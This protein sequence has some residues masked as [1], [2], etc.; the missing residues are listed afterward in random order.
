MKLELNIIQNDIKIMEKE[1]KEKKKMEHNI[2]NDIDNI[3]LSEFDNTFKNCDL[4]NK[5]SRN[6]LGDHEE[7]PR[8]RRNS[9]S[10]EETDGGAENTKVATSNDSDNE[11][12]ISL[13]YLPNIPVATSNDLNT[14]PVA[15]SNDLNTIPVATSNDLNTIPVATSNDLNTIPVATSNDSDNESVISLSYLPNIPVATSNDSDNESVISLSYLPNIPVATSNDLNT[16]PVATSNDLNTIPVATSNDLNTIP[17]ATSN[18]SDNE[19]VISLGNLS[20]TTLD[21]FFNDIDNNTTVDNKSFV[22]FKITKTSITQLKLK[23]VLEIIK[24]LNKDNWDSYFK[25]SS[26]DSRRT[27]ESGNNEILETRRLFI[28]RIKETFG[29]MKTMIESTPKLEQNMKKK[30]L[31]RNFKNTILRCC[32]RVEN[33][34]TDNLKNLR[35][36]VERFWLC[37]SN[38]E[39]RL[40]K[41]LCKF[42]ID[43]VLPHKD[44]NKPIKASSITLFI[45]KGS[46]AYE[47]LFKK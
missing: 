12:V 14:I 18:N 30:N 26:L 47:T 22:E 37:Y 23:K 4:S 33:G 15:T 40:T 42:F 34:I 35:K 25:T 3:N 21:D 13:S 20:N 45:E 5:R 6:N 36:F 8:K 24:L 44:D 17:V 27:N 28:K 16:I 38:V 9:I 39:S 19:S 1:I 2:L 11:S 46:E 29:E 10:K 41:N 7:P 32:D 31:D 43:A